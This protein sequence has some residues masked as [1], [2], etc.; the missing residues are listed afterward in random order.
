MTIK[1]I[2]GLLFILA[3]LSFAK[4][5]TYVITPGVGTDK[6]IVGKT[7]VESAF[8][9]LGKND[10]FTEGVAEGVDFAIHINRYIYTKLGVTIISHIYE[11]KG[12]DLNNA[13][14]DNIIFEAP[15]NSRTIDNIVLGVATRENIIKKYG[16]PDNDKTYSNINQLHYRKRGISFQ[17]DSKTKKL[18]SIEIYQPVN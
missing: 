10:R 13:I 7:K 3:I 9:L 15:S 16:Q 4:D 11:P 12:L 2:I 5:N 18:L 6:L 17:V 1:K 8:A 14:I